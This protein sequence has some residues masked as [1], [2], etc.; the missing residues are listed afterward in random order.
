MTELV[1]ASSFVLISENFVC[2]GSLF[3]LLFGF[4]VPGLRSGWNFIAICRYA[5]LISSGDD[6]RETPSIS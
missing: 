3:E 1:V 2:F 4:R 5:F 6:V